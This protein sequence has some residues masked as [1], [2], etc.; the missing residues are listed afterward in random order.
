M[1]VF[2]PANATYDVAVIGREAGRFYP[3]FLYNRFRTERGEYQRDANE[4]PYVVK[5][6][7]SAHVSLFFGSC[8]RGLKNQLEPVLRVKM[9]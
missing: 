3:G 4:F 8:S 1:F 2:N 9:F 6:D 7:D 5:S